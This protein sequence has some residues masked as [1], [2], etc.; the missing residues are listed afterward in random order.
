[1]I[2]SLSGTVSAIGLDYLV[3][4]VS[5]IGYLLKT[6]PPT[7]EQ[8]RHGSQL[9]LHTELV[10]RED[11]LTLYGFLTQDE[12][13]LFRT[14]QSVSGIGPRIAL[15]VLA[16]LT[17]GEFGR[18][19]AAEDIKTITMVPGIGPKGA[20]RIA[21]ELKDKAARFA[22]LGIDDEAALTAVADSD[23]DQGDSLPPAALD[24][25]TAL[26]GLG[27]AEKPARE[28]VLEVLDAE[29]DG[30]DADTPTLLRMSLRRLGG[31][32]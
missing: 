17:P 24:V 20:K 29:N 3:L 13:D 27:W 32:R 18:A 12:A 8:A 23:P 1:M 10:V 6:T 9:R 15:A 19:V 14:V 31:R 16:V 22:A 28:A 26:Q 30:Q 21:L 25:I 4:E 5:G 2:A 11:S 7:L